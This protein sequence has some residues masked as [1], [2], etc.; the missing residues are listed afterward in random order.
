MYIYTCVCTNTYVYIYIYIYT[1]I[2]THTHIYIWHLF[3]DEALPHPQRYSHSFHP[4]TGIVK[5][6]GTGVFT[7]S[8]F[9]LI[10]S[11]PSVL[12]RCGARASSRR[13]YSHAPC[14]PTGNLCRC[15]A[16]A[17]SQRAPLPH[18]HTHR[19]PHLYEHGNDSLVHTAVEKDS[20]I[21][22]LWLIFDSPSTLA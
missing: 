20:L 15:G 12:Y 1:Y 6:R 17:S 19:A 4:H 5:V 11:P 22:V 18:I 8:V 13:A 7:A 21:A 9:T 14:P 10:L 16:R 2:Y 3:W